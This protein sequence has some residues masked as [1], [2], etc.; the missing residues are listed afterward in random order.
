LRL[1][2]G[3]YTGALVEMSLLNDHG[4]IIYS[5]NGGWVERSSLSF[6]S[7][8]FAVNTTYSDLST[9]HFLFA[10]TPGS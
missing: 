8:I 1:N 5:P 6:C 7:I 2:I 3:W 4:R 9:H 10:T